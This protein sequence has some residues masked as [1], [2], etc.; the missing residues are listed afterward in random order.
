MPVHRHRVAPFLLA[1]C[2]S[3]TDSEHGK[4]Q[5]PPYVTLGLAARQSATGVQSSRKGYRFIHT[6]DGR[7][8]FSAFTLRP[9]RRRDKD[10]WWFCRRESGRRILMPNGTGSPRYGGTVS[11][12]RTAATSTSHVSGSVPRHAARARCCSPALMRGPRG[13]PCLAHLGPITIP[14]QDPK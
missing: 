7:V 1:G 3:L 9:I 2:A 13:S 14:V 4:G 10:A 5:M 11:A 6:R 12:T 8:H